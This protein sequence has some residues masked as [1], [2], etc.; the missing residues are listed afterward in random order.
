MLIAGCGRD[1]PDLVP[2]DEC[3]ETFTTLQEGVYGQVTF[4]NDVRTR[5]PSPAEPGMA[6][7]RLMTGGSD[8][9]IATDTTDEHGLYELP[10]PGG[11]YFICGSVPTCIGVEVPP[12]G[13][14]RID[15]HFPIVYSEVRE[16]C[17]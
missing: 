6:Q 8:V 2:L 17:F 9:P 3:I 7:L 4:A 1:C 13:R 15:I 14:I 10:A 16:P 11:S 12:T 5:C